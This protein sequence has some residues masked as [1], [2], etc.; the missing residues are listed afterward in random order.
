MYLAE[1][2]QPVTRLPRIGEAK[3]RDFAKL[4]VSTI[5]D[6]FLHLPRDYEDRTT[7]V[8][9]AAAPDK[10]VNTVAVVVA[11]SYVGRPPKAALMVHVR[12][13]TGVAVLACFGRNFLARSLPEGKRI[14]LYGA[15]SRKYG[16]LQA[17]SF[18]FE[19]A[20][21]P[22][23]AFGRIL[24][25]YPLAGRLSQ[26]DIRS[27]AQNALHQYG[28]N[29][30]NELP[31]W[32]MNARNL[33]PT[34]R[35]IEQLHAPSSTEAARSA[36]ETMVYV[37]LL[38]LQLSI[39]RRAAERQTGSR[40]ARSL[41]R[42]F[43]DRLLGSLPYRLTGEQTSALDE[44]LADLAGEVPMARLMQGDV[45]S[46]KTIVALASSLP[47]I[48]TGL[49]VAIMA[50]TELLARQHADAL[51][52]L[53][54][55]AGVDVSVGFL[56]GTVS[57]E[58]RRVLLQA[59]QSG[60]VDL[61]VGTHAV[62]TEEVAF[63]NLQYV[64]I[65]EQHRFGVLQRL[66][67]MK[68]ARYP[69]LLLMTATPIPRTLA[70]TVFGD[71]KVS[72]IRELP[73]GRSP[74]ETHL[75]MHRNASKVYSFVRRELDR[76]RQAYFVYPVIDDS[77]KLDLKDAEGMYD[78]LRRT[79]YPDRR[80]GL[81]HSR[82]PEEHKEET[83]AQFRDGAIDV[84]VATSVVEVG[85]DVPNATCM[86]V[87]H[88]ERFGLAA[89]HQLRGRVGRGTKQGYCF[90]IYDEDLTDLAKERLKVIHGTRDGFAIAEE[91]LRIRGPGDIIGT[92]QSGYLR[93]RVA[94]LVRD[95]DTMNTARK[96]AFD[97]VEQDRGLKL[98]RH[99]ELSEALALATRLHRMTPLSRTDA[100]IPGGRG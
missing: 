23:R 93:F 96:D 78:H 4:G 26:G 97:I 89:L 3:A 38:F 20:D 99:R 1:L 16:N 35:A 58:P 95:M 100:L 10:P 44:I 57:G 64:I 43:L 29:L 33:M 61:V 37:E 77:G 91:D 36:R 14:R 22:P 56:S 70:L 9:F 53:L 8:P 75:S 80:V 52:T 27:A 49:Q 11:H 41:P 45:G 60:Q 28:R 7:V 24:P 76:R 71:M 98:P 39:A 55:A 73:P 47:V 86:V 59:I 34:S 65:D 68:K 82:L 5:G 79:I 32:L 48:E 85:V 50:P 67:L 84:L 40:P 63:R 17:S 74:V 12:D 94:D 46:G 18:E 21:S 92:Q 15:F 30:D 2:T 13:D 90:L 88:A 81:V 19:D 42:G 87:E 51:T 31:E 6:L 54:S 72:T 25:V 83:M 66:A 62:F 69:D